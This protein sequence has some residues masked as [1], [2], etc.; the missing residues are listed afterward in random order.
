MNEDAGLADLVVGDKGCELT[1]L[2]TYGDRACRTSSD[3]I[4]VVVRDRLPFL[5]GIEPEH[6]L[7]VAL[8]GLISK[9]HRLVMG[10]FRI[11]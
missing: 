10:S 11:L 5:A 2:A 6:S 4:G 7:C 8:Q 1:A 3:R 9:A